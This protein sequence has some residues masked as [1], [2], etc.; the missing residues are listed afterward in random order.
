V[1][2]QGRKDKQGRGIFC[3]AD[4]QEMQHIDAPPSSLAYPKRQSANR[5][6]QVHNI[7]KNN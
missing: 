1:T 2:K 7:F 5:S 3:A 4:K 6:E